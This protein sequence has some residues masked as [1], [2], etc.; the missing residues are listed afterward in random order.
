MSAM[1]FRVAARVLGGVVLHR[2]F[3]TERP[4]RGLRLRLRAGASPML[5]EELSE[6]F[7]AGSDQDVMP[8]RRLAETDFDA[9]GVGDDGAA[10]EGDDGAAAVAARP[11]TTARIRK[12]PGMTRAE[13][14]EAEA[15]MLAAA[16]HECSVRELVDIH[17]RCVAMAGMGAR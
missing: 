12:R 11:W 16:R 8:A 10:G 17:K 2:G 3:Q 1:L 4:P 15:G 6:E 5:S 7:A 13:I 14:A 9:C